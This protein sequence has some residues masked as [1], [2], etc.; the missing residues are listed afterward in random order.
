[1]K[2]TIIVILI[3]IVATMQTPVNAQRYSREEWD[4]EGEDIPNRKPRSNSKKSNL[5]SKE[6]NLNSKWDFGTSVG[7]NYEEASVEKSIFGIQ[8]GVMGIWINNEIKLS[9]TIALRSEAGFEMTNWTIGSTFYNKGNE[10]FIPLVFIV[11]PRWYYDIKKR[12]S[13]G[14]YTANNTAT[15]ISVKIHYHADWL[16]LSGERPSNIQMTPTYTHNTPIAPTYTH[17]IQIMPT[18]ATRRN[19]G[20][21]FNYEVGGGIGYQHTFTSIEEENDVLAF[22]IVLR[23]GYTF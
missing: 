4:F 5:N 18:Y 2:K 15:F 1:M 6:S 17:N 14:L 3:A 13:K 22:N 8:A 21:Y 11:E 10:P 16:L 23:I 19:I 20:K 12:H 7:L 9:N